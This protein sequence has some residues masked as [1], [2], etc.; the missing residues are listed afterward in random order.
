MAR[1]RSRDSRSSL[2]ALMHTLPHCTCIG[3]SFLCSALML[4]VLCTCSSKDNS[5]EVSQQKCISILDLWSG[6]CAGQQWM[7]SRAL[8]WSYLS[9][10]PDPS[11][12]P[13]PS[14]LSS[15]LENLATQ[16]PD[17]ET[18]CSK[19]LFVSMMQCNKCS[20]AIQCITTFDEVQ[21]RT[22][23]QMTQCAAVKQMQLSPSME[24]LNR[25]NRR[26]PD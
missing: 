22:V 24:K 1:R 19:C 13:Q 10:H 16:T 23:Q 20:S 12:V 6:N 8:S 21:C 11:Q 18:H 2:P 7:K 14:L 9:G 4:S 15:H 26:K 17:G 25:L 3:N 5:K